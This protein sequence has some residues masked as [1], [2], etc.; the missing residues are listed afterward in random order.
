[1]VSLGGYAYA[2]FPASIAV[3]DLFAFAASITQG[4]VTVDI[5]NPQTGAL[6]SSSTA[7]SGTRVA[8]TNNV[9]LGRKLITTT[10]QR[11]SISSRFC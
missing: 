8:G 11:P 7:F 9:L 4:T 6:I 10:K 2:A 1:M 5:Y 3:G